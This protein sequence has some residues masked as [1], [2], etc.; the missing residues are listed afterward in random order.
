MN[1]LL[2]FSFIFL[3]LSCA[4]FQQEINKKNF[5]N[6]T[7]EDF[8][9]NIINNKGI[10]LDVRTIDELKSGIIEGASTINFYDSNFKNKLSKIQ[11]DKVVYVYCR[12]GGRSAK[13][14]QLL[15]DLGQKEVINLDG[16][17][18]AWKK[19]GYNLDVYDNQSDINVKEFTKQE[20]SKIINDNNLVL[21]NFHTLWCVPCRKMSPIID[22]LEQKYLNRIYIA[23]INL[24]KAY[25][26]EK[27][28]NINTVPAFILFKDKEIVWRGNGTISKDKLTGI[29]DNEL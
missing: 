11:K 13:A 18:M 15:I 1:K 12:S 14:A 24:D 10:I 27:D 2:F 28:F 22:E 17:I 5:K 21:V 3:S 16:G 23:R 20:L 6:L 7:A 9:T 8:Y 26:L 19:A 25:T 4:N 29:L